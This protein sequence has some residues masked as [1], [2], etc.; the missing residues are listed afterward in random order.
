MRPI[1]L[2]SIF[3]KVLIFIRSFIIIIAFLALGKALSLIIN[4]PIP[5]SITGLILLFSA[6]SLRFISLDLLLPAGQ[7]LLKYMILFIVPAG[8]GLI[9]HV[10]LLEEHWLAIIVSISVSTII[11]LLTV[12]WGY[13]R[14]NQ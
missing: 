9:N 7:A 2:S 4:L 12:G 10:G 11:V 6:L 14:I 1:T 13:Q 5:G 8:V 3:Y